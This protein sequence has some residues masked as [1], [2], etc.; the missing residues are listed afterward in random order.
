[1]LFRSGALDLDDLVDVADGAWKR[2]EYVGTDVK[3]QV[4]LSTVDDYRRVFRYES[5]AR[6]PIAGEGA[7]AAYPSRED[8][9]MHHFTGLGM[10]RWGDEENEVSRRCAVGSRGIHHG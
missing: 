6:R 2:L 8:R 5:S 4:K 1:M 3:V 10:E 7:S 9:N